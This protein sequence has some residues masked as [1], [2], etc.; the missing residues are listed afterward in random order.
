MSEEA[1]FTQMG[2]DV[3]DRL[4]VDAVFIPEIGDRVAL[5][6][7]PRQRASDQPVGSVGRAL[8]YEQEIEFYFADIGRLPEPGEQF[9]IDSDYFIVE[10][11]LE[12]DIQGRFCTVMVSNGIS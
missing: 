10:K 2:I 11:V 6:V 8:A 7:F 1:A 12:H 9:L 5:K 3:R 4:G